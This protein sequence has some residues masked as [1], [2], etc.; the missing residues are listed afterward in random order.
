MRFEEA[1]RRRS[2]RIVTLGL[3]TSAS[4]RVPTRPEA[5][6]TGHNVRYVLAFSLGGFIVAFLVVGMYFGIGI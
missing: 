1:V 4:R 2:G 3:S 5:G 6:V